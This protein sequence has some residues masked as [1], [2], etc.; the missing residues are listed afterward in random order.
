M[1]ECEENSCKNV[2]SAICLDCMHRLCIYHIEDHQKVQLSKVDELKNQFN[3]VSIDLTKISNTMVKERKVD[4]KKL[5]AWRKQ[6]IA[7]IEREYSKMRNSIKNRQKILE[8][9]QLELNQRL[10][11]EVQQPLEH[12]CTQKSTNPQLLD[13][14]QLSIETLRRDSAL[15]IWNSQQ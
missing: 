8:Q 7:E 2:Q 10:K 11:V 15:L 3:Q 9:M 14:I 1:F 12:M 6:K 5:S 13:A 4:E